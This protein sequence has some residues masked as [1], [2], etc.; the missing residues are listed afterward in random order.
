MQTL[1]FTLFQEALLK[2]QIKDRKLSKWIANRK[3]LT[4]EY[5]PSN[6]KKITQRYNELCS[7]SDL[8]MMIRFRIGRCHPL[9]GDRKGQFALDLE[10][11]KRLIIEPTKKSGVINVD[12]VT[13]VTILKVEDDYHG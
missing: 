4:Q 9:K 2:V 11:P 5:G 13:E 10:N 3:K 12:T 1:F 6:A 8:G 7:S